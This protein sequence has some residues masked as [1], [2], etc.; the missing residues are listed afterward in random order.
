MIRT[1]HRIQIGKGGNRKERD[2]TEE[3]DDCEPPKPNKFSLEEIAI[4]SVHVFPNLEQ[5]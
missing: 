1:T 2:Q 3:T 4:G 5:K